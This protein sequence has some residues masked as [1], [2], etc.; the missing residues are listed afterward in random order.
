MSHIDN[1]KAHN[2][3]LPMEL[4]QKQNYFTPFRHIL[5]IEMTLNSRTGSAELKIH[6]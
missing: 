5:I 2:I 3:D 6:I 1:K 4:I